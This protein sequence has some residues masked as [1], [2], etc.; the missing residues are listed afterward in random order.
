MSIKI[1]TDSSC[2]LPAETIE[3]WGISIVPLTVRFGDQEYVDGKT[4]TPEEF[5]HRMK[6]TRELPKTTQPS[7]AS[8]TEAFARPRKEDKVLCLTL[9]SRLSG[10]YRS[11][12]V[13]KEMVE[14]E[15]EVIDTLKG[16]LGLGILAIKAAQLALKGLELHQITE[17]VLKLR[18]EINILVGLE[19]LENLIKGGRLNRFTGSIAQLLN[20]KAILHEKDGAVELLERVRGKKKF[21]KR[22]VE[23][24]GERGKTLENKIIGIAHADNLEDALV[25]KQAFIERFN[26]AEVMVSYM[27]T[28]IGTYAGQGGL[29]I[30]F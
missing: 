15:V 30:S 3:K 27:G 26:P 18:D 25:L 6:E 2:D 23:I 28:T 16:T 21:L 29:T 11:A 8:F 22:L 4:I 14:T 10:T 19:T 1:V 7:P 5:Y 17:A 13:A 12:C 20:V 24:V 9:S